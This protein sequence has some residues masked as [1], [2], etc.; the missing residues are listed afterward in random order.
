MLLTHDPQSVCNNFH[1]PQASQRVRFVLS[2]NPLPTSCRF[3][4]RECVVFF[5]GTA[6]RMESQIP[7]MIGMSTVIDGK[8]N[9]R[10]GGNARIEGREGGALMARCIRRMQ[11]GVKETAWY[12]V[13]SVGDFASLCSAAIA[14]GAHEL[15]NRVA[16]RSKML[17]PRNFKFR[18]ANII[19]KVFRNCKM[20]FMHT[21][22]SSQ[23]FGGL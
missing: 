21:Y 4:F 10:D 3:R 16:T 12:C 7:V 9:R 15:L 20:M 19:S 6:R 2:S 14:F 23:Q 1:S 8:V 11:I 5:F 18:T 13:R 17:I 22:I